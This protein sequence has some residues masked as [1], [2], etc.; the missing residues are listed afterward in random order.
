MN[1]RHAFLVTCEHGGN[2]VPPRYRDCFAGHEALLESHRGYDPGALAIARDLARALHAPLIYATTSRLLVDLNRTLGH[3][4]LHSDIIRTLPEPIRCEILDRYYLP[5]RRR[6]EALIEAEVAAGRSVIHVSSHSFTPVLDGVVR[7][8]D[9]GLLYDPARGGEQSLCAEWLA[10]LR[11]RAPSLRVRRNYPYTG[12]SDGFTAY[13]R[14]CFGPEGYVGI[15]LEINQ[16]FVRP[17][18]PGWHALRADIVAA[19]QD[20][21]GRIAV[22]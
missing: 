6:A 14:R 17:V 7:Q 10:R 13:L 3:P 12:K 16:R 5:F 11:A 20:A 9:V 1:A 2:R 15:E 18:Q 4:R 8:A 22:R 19:L 21:L